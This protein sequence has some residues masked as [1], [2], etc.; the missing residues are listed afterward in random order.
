[1]PVTAFYGALLAALFIYLSARVI[2]VRRR[3]RVEIGDGGE[4]ALLRRMRVQAN[5][6][7]YTPLA[8]IMMLLAESLA[9]SW[10]W[11]HIIGLTLLCGRLIHAYGLSQEPHILKLRVYGMVL[12]FVALGAA[13]A[14]A[15]V[16]SVF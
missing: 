7:E 11:L 8:L 6:A 1:M 5:F 16:L 10:I 9:A 12:T 3:D 15:L 14:T 2:M 13:A 4:R